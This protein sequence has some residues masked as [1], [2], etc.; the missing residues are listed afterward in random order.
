MDGYSIYKI[1]TKPSESFFSL[2]FLL[3]TGK[4]ERLG[5]STQNNYYNFKRNE[6]SLQIIC[7][8]SILKC[9]LIQ[10]SFFSHCINLGGTWSVSAFTREQ[11]KKNYTYKEKNKDNLTAG[12]AFFFHLKK[13]EH[14]FFTIFYFILMCRRFR[15]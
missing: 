6:H 12:G 7:F 11:N 2:L 10:I 15:R 13:L 8:M 9:F 1:L 5:R 14:T 4:I 3:F